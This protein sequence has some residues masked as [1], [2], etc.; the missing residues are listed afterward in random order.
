LLGNIEE[1]KRGVVEP[2]ERGEERTKVLGEKVLSFARVGFWKIILTI[3]TENSAPKVKRGENR[4]GK[5][6]KGTERENRGRDLSVTSECPSK[7]N[8]LILIGRG[9]KQT[10]VRKG[11][12]LTM[13]GN[14]RRRVWYDSFV[15]TKPVSDYDGRP[16]GW[17]G[18][19][20]LRVKSFQL[21]A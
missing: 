12:T 8:K 16:L 11:K 18:D 4:Q 3:V 17:E 5:Q 1:A 2:G 7:L 9:Q 19:R 13:C 15:K 10:K 20:P 14:E 21:L 6:G